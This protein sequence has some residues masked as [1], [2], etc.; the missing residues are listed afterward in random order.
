[1][2][3]QQWEK[4]TLA[5]Y[6]HQFKMEAKQCNFSN[7]TATIRIFVKGL[8]N[9]PSLEAHIYEKDL[10]T[11]TDAIIEVEKLNAAQQL[12]MT[13][14]PSSAVN[15]MSNEEDQCF[16]RQELGHITRHH[17]HIR[18][19][20]YD[21]YQHIIMNCPHKIPP[22]GTPVTHHQTHRKSMHKIEL[23]APSGRSGK[24]RPL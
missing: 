24:K 15:M 13:I 20:E 23:K 3:I 12:T 21:E 16:Q 1:M 8:K 14:S 6:V 5:A 17:P 4:K 9:P 18:S 19:H 10:Q 11:L 2:D 7:H 22:L